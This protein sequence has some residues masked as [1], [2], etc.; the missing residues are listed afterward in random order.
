MKFKIEISYEDKT[1]ADGKPDYELVVKSDFTDDAAKIV[2]KTIETF[3]KSFAE[4]KNKT[5]YV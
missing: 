1:D 3:Q 5:T 4:I 2:T